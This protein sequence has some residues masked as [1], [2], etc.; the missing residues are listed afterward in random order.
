MQ[1]I[2]L[3]LLY[4]TRIALKLLLHCYLP[5]GI[6]VTW[7]VA[8]FIFKQFNFCLTYRQY[9]LSI[10]VAGYDDGT[11]SPSWQPPA[12]RY[13]NLFPTLR[14]CSAEWVIQTMAL[15]DDLRVR[16]KST[17]NLSTISDVS[18]SNADVGSIHPIHEDWYKR[19]R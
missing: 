10:G 13:I 3:Q 4:Q 7:S 19:E 15:S 18:E 6:S 17:R 16:T 12:N 1:R 5:L 8:N 14:L 2:V 9:Y 11:S